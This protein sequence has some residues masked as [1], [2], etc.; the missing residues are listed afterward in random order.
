MITYDYCVFPT[1]WHLPPQ[2]NQRGQILRSQNGLR[3]FHFELDPIGTAGLGVRA[4]RATSGGRA[5]RA[6]DYGSA[7]GTRRAHG[8]GYWYAGFRPH[9]PFCRF[10]CETALSVA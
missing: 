2:G 4:Q 8:F 7:G 9:E 5:G 3:D 1:S 10:A 6:H